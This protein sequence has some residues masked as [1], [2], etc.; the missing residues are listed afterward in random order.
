MVIILK[1]LRNCSKVKLI[2]IIY[3]IKLSFHHVKNMRQ[4]INQS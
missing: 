3:D 1:Y 2:E 4:Q